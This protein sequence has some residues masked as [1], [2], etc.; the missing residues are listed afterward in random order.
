MQAV[1]VGRSSGVI[2]I[3]LHVSNVRSVH[4]APLSAMTHNCFV[5]PSARLFLFGSIFVIFTL[6][7]GWLA[8]LDSTHFPVALSKWH[9]R[10]LM[11]CDRLLARIAAAL[12]LMFSLSIMLSVMI[13][14]AS[15][16]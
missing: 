11:L 6:I 4:M 12:V 14:G 1:D 7:Y 8:L 2:P 15:D 13:G 9:V 16:L 10:I 5:S 3:C